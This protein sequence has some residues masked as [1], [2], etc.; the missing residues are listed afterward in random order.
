M[1]QR[2]FPHLW[3]NGKSTQTLSSI[4]VVRSGSAEQQHPSA[5]NYADRMFTFQERI[6]PGEITRR[7]HVEEWHRYCYTKEDVVDNPSQMDDMF[8][9]V[10]DHSANSRTRGCPVL[11]IRVA[12][13]GQH[14]GRGHV[15]TSSVVY[16][17]QCTPT[18]N[19]HS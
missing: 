2:S 12:W 9:Q 18:G 17:C 16:S 4:L 8:T 7:I 15:A 1:T 3:E 5:Q 11:A 6:G 10:R 19:Q 14:P 13:L